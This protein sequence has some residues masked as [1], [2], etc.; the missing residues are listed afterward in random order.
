M[1]FDKKLNRIVNTEKS[2]VEFAERME[3]I[4]VEKNDRLAM[5][6]AALIVFIPTMLFVIA[7]FCFAIWLF[8]GRFL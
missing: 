7:I 4:E 1:L 3:D 8:F 2:E 5:I 6:I